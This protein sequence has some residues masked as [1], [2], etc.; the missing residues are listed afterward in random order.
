MT[1]VKGK[2]FEAYTPG[3]TKGYVLEVYMPKRIA[4]LSG[5]Y[6]YLKQELTAHSPERAAIQGFS[7]YSVDGAF[8]GK[9]QT[10]D[11]ATLV[12]RIF[13]DAARLKMT[14]D[15]L[16]SEAAGLVRLNAKVADIFTS[17]MGI[18]DGNEEE[19]WVMRT[20]THVYKAIR[21]GKTK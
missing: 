14:N 13:F 12:I 5:V 21:K 11:E 16:D 4:Y 19:I 18:A 6:G 2:K 8:K 7:V 3:S 1:R 15:D 9:D 10:Y 17:L 20:D